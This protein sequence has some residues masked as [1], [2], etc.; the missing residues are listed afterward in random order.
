MKSK[1]KRRI[2]EI[3]MSLESDQVREHIRHLVAQVTTWAPLHEE[4]ARWHGSDAATAIDAIEERES[5]W[6]RLVHDRDEL[7]DAISVATSLDEV[8][9][10]IGDARDFTDAERS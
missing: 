2:G 10:I 1:K 7:L 9:E 4:S 3:V 8:L 5:W 6:L